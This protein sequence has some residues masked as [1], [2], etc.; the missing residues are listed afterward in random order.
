MQQTTSR[1]LEAVSRIRETGEESI[2]KKLLIG[3]MALILGLTNVAS[4]AIAIGPSEKMSYATSDKT[5]VL[6]LWRGWLIG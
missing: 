6:Q 5:D 1:S 4:S 2:V 3:T